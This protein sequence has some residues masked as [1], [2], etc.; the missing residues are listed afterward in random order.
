MLLYR[1]KRFFVSCDRNHAIGLAF[2]AL[3]ALLLL[4]CVT[5]AQTAAP[6]LYEVRREHIWIP[7]KD[8]VRLAAD[9]FMPVGKPGEK[10][11]AVFKYDPYRK[12][13]NPGI[14]SECDINIYF[15]ARG[16]V[17]ACVDIRGTGQSE[18]HAPNREYSEQELS[19]G[20]EISA[21][22]ASQPWSSGAVGVFGKSWSGFNAIQLAMRNPPA[23]KAIITVA[24]TEKL[25][26]EDV[27]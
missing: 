3:A 5:R 2:S 8:G 6:K 26:N 11:P 17:G 16:Y 1:S 24:S 18:G 7:M 20:E 19:D 4:T 21:W 22:L 9:L 25:Y 15:A 12:D 13:D 14:F 23:L 27:H 10:F